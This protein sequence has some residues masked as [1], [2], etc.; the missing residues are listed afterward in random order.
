MFNPALLVGGVAGDNNRSLGINMAIQDGLRFLWTSQTNRAANFPAG[1]TTYWND[2]GVP[3]RRHFVGRSGVREPGLQDNGQCRADGHLRK[4]HRS[5]WAELRAISQLRTLGH[6]V[7]PAGNNP[8]VVYADCIGLAPPGDQ[9]YTTALAILGFAGSGALAQVNTEVAGYTNG[10]TYGEILQRLVNALAWGQNDM[11]ATA[12]RLVLRL[13]LHRLD[14][15]T[16]GWDML[17]LLDAAAAGATVPAWVKTEYTFGF[18]NA[19]NTDGSFDYNGDGNPASNNNAGPPKNGIGLQG[20]FLIGETRRRPRRRGQD[21]T[22][23]LVDW[24]PGGI[25]GDAWR[26]RSTRAAPTRCST[27]SRA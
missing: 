11:L 12:G 27:T 19:L 7:T 24:R 6:G 13:Q 2:T 5:P 23:R 1:T 8:C 22:Q 14:G 21:H 25:G 4:V 16:V 26:D 20:L 10:K 17:A 15:S 9:G 18:N 3:V